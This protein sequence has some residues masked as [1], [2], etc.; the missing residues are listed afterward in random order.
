MNTKDN[1]RARDLLC[2]SLTGP[3]KKDVGEFEL[4]GSRDPSLLPVVDPL[5]S[6]ALVES[7]PTGE[8]GSPTEFLD[9]RSVSIDVVFPVH[10]LLNTT[11][12]QKANTMLNN[13]VFNFENIRGM[14]ETTARLYEAARLLRGLTTPTEIARLLNVAPQNV[15][16]WERRGMSKA[17]MLDAQEKLGCSAVWLMTGEGTMLGS[18]PV[19]SSNDSSKRDRSRPEIEKSDRTE[20]DIVISSD[21]LASA[22]SPRRLRAALFDKGLTTA[23][24]ASVA[25]VSE[26]VAGQWL[27]GEGPDITLAQGAALQTAYGVNVVWLT[28]GKGEPGVAIRYA[29]EYEPIPITN[30]RAVPVVGHAQLGDNGYWADLEYPVGAGDGY[31]DFPSRD[32]NAYAL[33]CVGDSMRPRIKDGEFVV[34]EPNQA[35]EAGD[36]VLVKS[37]AGQVMVKEFLYRRAGRVHLRSANDAHKPISFSSDEIEKMHF[38]RAICR[39]SSWRPD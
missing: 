20:S 29:D 13:K 16:N 5:N 17:A 28:K 37:K 12:N 8:L 30:W 3:I 19:P 35:I 22:R 2:E 14:H 7:Q 1:E 26:S 21:D 38:V 6:T 34:I 15:N 18:A 33:K 32:P 39:P 36:E 9:E 4:D 27:D 31:V 11:F 23:E 25:G 24:I 10:A